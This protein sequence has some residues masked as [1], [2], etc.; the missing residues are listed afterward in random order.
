MSLDR[1]SRRLIQFVISQ[2]EMNPGEDCFIKLVN[3]L[4][5]LRALQFHFSCF[6]AQLS[7]RDLGGQQRLKQDAKQNS[8]L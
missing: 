3:D 2:H 5:D 6:D 4:K 1:R 7:S 8:G